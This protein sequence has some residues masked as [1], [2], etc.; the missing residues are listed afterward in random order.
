MILTDYSTDCFEIMA[1]AAQ[2]PQEFFFRGAFSLRMKEREQLKPVFST[3]SLLTLP[4]SIA[5]IKVANF[6]VS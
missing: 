4:S 1:G 5:I 6:T 2:I 3:D